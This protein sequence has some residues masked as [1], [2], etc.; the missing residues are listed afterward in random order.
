LISRLLDQLNHG[1]VYT[2]I[3]L[4]EA[5]NLVH[6][7]EGNEWKNAILNTLWCHVTW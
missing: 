7:W 3:D 5:Y 2:K 6:I 1:K 4:R